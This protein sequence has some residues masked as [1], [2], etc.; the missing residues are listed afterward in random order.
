MALANLTNMSQLLQPEVLGRLQ[1]QIQFRRSNLAD[2]QLFSFDDGGN[3]M[4][5]I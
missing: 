1:V 5:G 2:K 3:M 4:A